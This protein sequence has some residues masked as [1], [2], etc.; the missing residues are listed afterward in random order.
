MPASTDYFASDWRGVL[1]L[2]GLRSFEDFWGLKAD[3]FEAPNERRG[4]W[5]GVARIELRLPDGGT[6]GAFLKRQENH[7]TRTWRHPLRGQATLAR[8]FDNCLEFERHHIPTVKPLYFGLRRVDGDLRAVLL[9]EELAGFRSLADW[10]TEWRAQG[11]PA[12]R[13]RRQIAEAL[14]AAV[15][16]MHSRRFR[17]Q[18][19]YPK[20]LFLRLPDAGASPRGA[21]PEVRIIDLEKAKRKAFR[22]L[23]ARRDLSTLER[24]CGDWSLRDRIRFY[25]AY[26]R[27]TR[28]RGTERLWRA[29]ERTSRQKRRRSS[30]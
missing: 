19:L 28:L 25:R 7:V 12:P 13:R 3:W 15:R 9:T 5:S 14:A 2:N 22:W 20:H 17:H 10:M 24:H 16:L 6:R 23:A 18:C 1:E 11:P 8:E 29:V 4:G 30:T 26:L 21:G 27:V